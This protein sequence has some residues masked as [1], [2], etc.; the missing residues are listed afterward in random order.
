MDLGDLLDRIAPQLD[1]IRLVPAADRKPRRQYSGKYRHGHASLVAD[2]HRKAAAEASRERRARVQT[3]S[4]YVAPGSP[5]G[6]VNLQ[7]CRLSRQHRI[8]TRPLGGAGR[9]ILCR[10]VRIRAKRLPSAEGAVGRDI[11]EALDNE[12][13]V[14]NARPSRHM[15]DSPASV[16]AQDMLSH[17]D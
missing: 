13:M 3:Y 4:C 14:M 12:Y 6:R 5:L 7:P 9:I 11:Y 2:A 16:A 1:Q 10:L 8:D 15:L 17:R